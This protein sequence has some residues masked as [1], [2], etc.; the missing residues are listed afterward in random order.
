MLHEAFGQ[1]FLN[2][3]H[4]S[5]PIECELKM[6]NVQGDQAPAKRGKMLKNRE[7]VHEGHS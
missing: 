4:V 2:V 5:R 6:K 1:L 3:I 7:L